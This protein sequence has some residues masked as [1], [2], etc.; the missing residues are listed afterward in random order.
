M[1]QNNVQQIQ[2]YFKRKEKGNE[3]ERYF[4]KNVRQIAPFEGIFQIFFKSKGANPPQTP[5][6]K[7]KNILLT[8]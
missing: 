8:L 3:Q 2:N 7:H 5:P 4:D 6:K 1:H